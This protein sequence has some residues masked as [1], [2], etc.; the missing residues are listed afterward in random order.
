MEQPINNDNNIT[1][2]PRSKLIYDYTD[3][4][5]KAKSDTIDALNVRLGLLLATNVTLLKFLFDSRIKRLYIDNWYCYSC[6]GLQVFLLFISVFCVAAS[7]YFCLKG[8]SPKGIG[9]VVDPEELMKDEWYEA[10]EEIQRAYI[11]IK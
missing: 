10:L 5:H 4:L 3:K 8:L 2:N 1:A 11:I 7:I 9:I 6:T